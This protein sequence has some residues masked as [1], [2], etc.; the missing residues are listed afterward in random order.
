MSSRL[1]LALR[2]VTGGHWE[3]F[4][5]FSSQ[6]L[7]DEYPDLR[8]LASPSGDEGRDA[9]LWQ[10][11]EVASVAI[12]YSV[13][14]GWDDKI[15]RT[16]NRLGQTH[17]QVSVLIYMTNQL[18]GAQGDDRRR[19]ALTDKG[20]HL[21]IRDRSW[22]IERE[23]SSPGRQKASSWFSDFVLGDSTNEHH[24]ISRSGTALSSE[25]TRSALL[26]LVLQ[27][28]D[29]DLDRH[30]TKLC[31]DA[32]VRMVLRDTDNENRKHR[33]D[34]HAEVAALL[35]TQAP[36]EVA[37]YVDRALERMNKRFIRHWMQPDEFCL[38][39]DERVR[40]A[41]SIASLRV[42]D[43]DFE[44]ELVEHAQFVAEGMSLDLSLLGGMA[45]ITQRLRRVLE[46][47]LFERGEAFVKSLESGQT[48]MFV[49]EELQE[50]ATQDVARSPETSSIRG[51]IVPLVGPHHRESV[52]TA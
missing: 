25:E 50:L 15:R 41:E 38:T 20:I 40:I 23:S 9:F 45:P 32:L 16:V 8:T 42:V 3:P 21:D 34:I 31:Y 18:I 29:D 4:E 33:A 24:L 26:Y 43:N 39:F 17:P 35:P 10:P 37:G 6:F 12:Q 36:D 13:A 14:T 5:R 28:K 46:Q 48:M 7:A 47:F 2:N 22:F 44:R 27:R 49:E 51:A 11:V 30:L 19:K 52:A 1:D